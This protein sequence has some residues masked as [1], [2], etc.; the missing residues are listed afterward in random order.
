MMNNNILFIGAGKMAA[1]IAG[2]MLGKGFAAAQI[3]A[4][5]I[6]PQAAANF[7]AATGVKVE[8][9]RPDNL[10]TQA[11]AVVIAVKPQ[12]L[13]NALRDYSGRLADKLIISIVAGT[14]V[15]R[16][17]ELTGATR[18][19]RVMPN[20]PALVGQAASAWCASP[21]TTETDL[22]LLGRILDSIGAAWKVDEKLLDAVT[23]LSGSGPAYVLD[24]IQ[25][26]AD[27]GVNAGLPRDTA[28]AL[29][30][31]TV[32]GTA[33]LLLKSGRHPAVLRDEVTSPGGTTARALAVLEKH[34][35]KGTVIEAVLAAAARSE[36]LGKK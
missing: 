9:R 13:T 8:T 28:L 22:K 34:G 33:E 1:A 35:F 17:Q 4:F 18:I 10:L 19:I 32:L 31:Q 5:D 23:G 15:A 30:V 27:G 3:G 2:G 29:A 36:E 6:S 21:G 7:T 11:A 16:L 20:T 12:Q 14:A 25:A 24:F 26:L